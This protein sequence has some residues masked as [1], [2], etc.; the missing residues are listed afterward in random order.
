MTVGGAP[1]GDAERN[2]TF[3]ELQVTLVFELGRSQVDLATLRSI[4][5][6]YV[7]PLVRDPDAPVDL[8]VNGRCIGKGE[9]V[10]IGET[11]GIRTTRLFG[12]E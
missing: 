11:L 2:T 6:G 1:F 8:V 4:A 12:H 9:I 5:P 7:F 10:R 3:D